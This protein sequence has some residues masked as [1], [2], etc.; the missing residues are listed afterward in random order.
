MNLKTA[1][2]GERA[3]GRQF[4]APSYAIHEV[5][6]RKGLDRNRKTHSQRSCLM[7]LAA[8][9]WRSAS[10]SHKS[11]EMIVKPMN[12]LT[13]RVDGTR[14]RSTPMSKTTQLRGAKL[15]PVSS[16]SSEGLIGLALDRE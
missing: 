15:S 8:R 14:L 1:V 2:S 7:N 3:G 6:P 10:V 13:D 4:L 5:R 16:P 12:P 11:S 9:A